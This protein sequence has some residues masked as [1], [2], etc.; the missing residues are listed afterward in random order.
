MLEFT[1]KNNTVTVVTGYNLELNLFLK[2]LKSVEAAKNVR[3]EGLE[4]FLEVE[5][6][7]LTDI[8]E[9]VSIFENPNTGMDIFWDEEFIKL[10]KRLDNNEVF[11]ALRKRYYL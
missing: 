8:K 5:D 7:L 3:T 6:T 9:Y 1:I 4:V 10:G 2:E 11:Q